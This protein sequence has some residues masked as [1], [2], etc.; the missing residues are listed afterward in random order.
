MSPSQEDQLAT[1]YNKTPLKIPEPGSGVEA[2]PWITETRKNCVRRVRAGLPFDCIAPPPGWPAS[3]PR[4]SPRAY[5]F[6]CGKKRA[7]GGHPASPAFQDASQEAHF[8]LAL[9]ESLGESVGLDQQGSARDGGADED[10]SK[11]ACMWLLADC[12]AAGGGT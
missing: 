10:H 7:Q 6:S 12:V 5:N 11:A 1:V 4:R 3:V 8:S 9:Q 2:Y